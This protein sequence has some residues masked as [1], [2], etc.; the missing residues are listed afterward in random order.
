[1]DVV[2]NGI[3]V[4][5]IEISAFGDHLEVRLK[6]TILLV[7]HVALLCIQPHLS[8]LDLLDKDHRVQQPAGGGND[9]V[10]PFPITLPAHLLILCDQQSSSFWDFTREEH[11]TSHNGTVGNVDDRVASRLWGNN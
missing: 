2:K 3:A 6:R 9:D 10:V 11:S 8:L 5:D 7:Q 1:M 4:D